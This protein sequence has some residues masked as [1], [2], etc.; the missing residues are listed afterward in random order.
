MASV[1]QCDQLAVAGKR[2][3]FFRHLSENANAECDWGASNAE[4]PAKDNQEDTEAGG[5]RPRHRPAG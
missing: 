2:Y 3:H 1:Q 4:N 5:D